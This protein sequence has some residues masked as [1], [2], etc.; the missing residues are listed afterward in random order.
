MMTQTSVTTMNV[1]MVGFGKIGGAVARRVLA[2]GHSVVGWARRRDALD[3]FVAQ[4]GIAVQTLAEIGKADV[5]I[6]VVFDDAA[7]RAVAMEPSGFIHAMRPGAIHVAMATI[8]PSLSRELH[9]AHAERGQRYL[10]AP[11]FGRPE[12]AA[13]GELAIM[14]SGADETYRI[15]K[16]ILATSGT[17]RWVGRSLSR[18]CSSSW[19]ETI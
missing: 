12:A 13:K 14:C 7:T 15:V 18:P 10:A 2:A 8:S 16:P 3:G 4:G 6:S 19:L 9:D 11:V 5:V 17:T 1:G